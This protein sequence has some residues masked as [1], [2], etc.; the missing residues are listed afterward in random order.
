MSAFR[1]VE[2]RQAGERALGI[3]VPL[4]QRTVVILRPR[5]LDWDLLPA[6]WNGDAAKA[7]EFCHFSRDEAALVARRVQQALEAAVQ[8]GVSPVQ[9]FGDRSRQ[10]IWVRAGEFVWIVCRRTPGQAYQPMVFGTQDEAEQAGQLLECYFWPR[11]ADQE[12]YFNT[13]LFSA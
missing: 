10:Q 6:R 1:R 12:V 3:L 2:A 4:G 7:P 11:Q 5:G 13:Q 8:A 9:S